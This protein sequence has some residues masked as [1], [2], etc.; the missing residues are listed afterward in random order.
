MIDNA[1]E[2]VDT[3]KTAEKIHG[4][5]LSTTKETIG[6][7]LRKTD[8]DEI[9]KFGETTQGTKRYTKK[10]YRENGVYMDTMAAGS[11]YDMHMWQHNKILEYTQE[12]G[13]RP[14]WNKSDW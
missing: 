2:V 5:S 6:Y 11:K 1:D 3:M 8:T 9:M 12:R 13:V 4:N 10:F 14:P 7:A